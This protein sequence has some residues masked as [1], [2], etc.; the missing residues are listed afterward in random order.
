VLPEAVMDQ[1]GSGLLKVRKAR[2]A[3]LDGGPASLAAGAGAGVLSAQ[4]RGSW[5]RSVAF[6]V[7]HDRRD[8]PHFPADE[9]DDRLPALV[10]PVL[11]RLADRLADTDVGLLLSDTDARIL[12][13]W[14]GESS[15]GRFFDRVQ[16]RRGSQLSEHA[17][18]TNGV[19]TPVV[20]GEL[21][22]VQGPEH[23][24]DMYQRAVCTGAPIR[25]PITRRILGAVTLTCPLVPESGLLVPLL[26][27]TLDE[28]ERHL[29]DRAT[30]RE[31]YLLDAFRTAANATRQPVV[32]LL[33]GTHVTSAAA[34]RLLNPLDLALI[35][36]TVAGLRAAHGTVRVPVA[37]S[38]GRGATAVCTPAGP[39]ERAGWI[40]QIVLAG[41]GDRGRAPVGAHPEAPLPALVGSSAA[42]RGVLRAAHVYRRSAVPV[43]LTGEPGAGKVATALAMCA[44]V[45]RVVLLDAALERVD[46]TGAW[47]AR[48]RTA[49]R[50]PSG[51]TV[52]RHLDA[53]SPAAV[54]GAAA[55]LDALPGAPAILATTRGAHPDGAAAPLLDRFGLATIAVP[56][57]R[58]RVDD[59]PD[60]VRALARRHAPAAALALSGDAVRALRGH[61]WPGNV[62]E[63][64]G[65]VRRLLADRVPV[66][67]P[68][69]ALPVEI[70][71][72]ADGRRL[73][74]LETLELDAIRSALRGAA[75]NRAR[76]AA[77]LGI[78]RATLYR[79]LRVFGPLLDLP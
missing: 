77:A 35:E 12:R 15:I 59:L 6:R 42:W 33:G 57:L 32:A 24:L 54:D 75:G 76:A 40:V 46:G 1:H 5:L 71:A 66:P 60:L 43:L 23:V 26:A 61:P 25:D 36:Q 78:S 47:L 28:V 21:V 50:R 65:V 52:I 39:D 58:E 30:H 34:R 38:G 69:S 51:A 4:I 63:L 29:L 2:E 74:A 68:L 53:L 64:D 37:L 49:L 18:G 45:G 44:G 56:P 70:A 13:R 48:L 73:T 55:M 72:C 27:G 67:V 14:S 19:G 22:Q 41:R 20:V 11:E 62:R 7:P 3:F 79:R 8:V 17:V 16:T 9:L 31:R 10:G